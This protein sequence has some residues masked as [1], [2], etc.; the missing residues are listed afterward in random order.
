MQAHKKSTTMHVV[1]WKKI[2]SSGYP[3][4]DVFLVVQ[5]ENLLVLKQT[6]TGKITT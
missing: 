3:M 4:P 1:L 2:F 6:S 5:D